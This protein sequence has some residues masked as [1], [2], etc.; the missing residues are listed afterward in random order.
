[1]IT[2]LPFLASLLIGYGLWLLYS[3]YFYVSPFKG[4]I[5]P[6]GPRGW[7]LIGNWKLLQP[8]K[9]EEIFMQW[10]RDYGELNLWFPFLNLRYSAS[11]LHTL[12]VHEIFL[13]SMLNRSS[14][15]K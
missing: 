15:C 1:M 5:L 7:W 4:S 11:L 13:L 2:I 3:H 8:E 9:Y 10:G 14:R 12:L 6:P